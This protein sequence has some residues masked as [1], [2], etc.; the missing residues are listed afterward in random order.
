MIF[1]FSLNGADKFANS[2]NNF[3]VSLGS[4][5]SSAINASAVSKRIEHFPS[6][7]LFLLKVFLDY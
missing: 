3:L 7:P 1:A 2:H 5:I 4:M 6:F